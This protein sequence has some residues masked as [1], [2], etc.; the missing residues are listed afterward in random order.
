MQDSKK[1]RA[2]FDELRDPEPNANGIALVSAELLLDIRDLLTERLP[3][4]G[5]QVAITHIVHPEDGTYTDA[6]EE[7]GETDGG[8]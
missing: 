7:T 4:P 6:G 2:Y 1:L 5:E 8:G 3:V